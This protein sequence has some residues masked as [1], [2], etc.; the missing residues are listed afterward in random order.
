MQWFVHKSRWQTFHVNESWTIL[1]CIRSYWNWNWN[2][3]TLC[4]PLVHSST[5]YT[6]RAL[7]FFT[8]SI[9]FDLF[10]IE[11]NWIA[12]GLLW[13][14]SFLSIYTS[15]NKI[16]SSELIDCWEKK[17]FYDLEKMGWAQN[18]IVQFTRNKLAVK[19]VRKRN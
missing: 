17:F 18:Y 1:S 2:Y 8:L 3:M 5:I 15:I 12:N 14:N 11:C 7:R 9:P 6:W 10:S 13:T 19:R 16:C 4:F